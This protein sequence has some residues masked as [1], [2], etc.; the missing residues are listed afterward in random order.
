MSSPFPSELVTA[1]QNARVA[2]VF[3]AKGVRNVWVAEGPDFVHTATTADP[4]QRR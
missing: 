1:T 4:L 3:H 2:W